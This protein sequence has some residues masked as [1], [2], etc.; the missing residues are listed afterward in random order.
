M[1][2]IWDMGRGYWFDDHPP[3]QVI[4]SHLIVMF[5]LVTLSREL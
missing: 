5:A 2:K 3:A 4:T 1:T